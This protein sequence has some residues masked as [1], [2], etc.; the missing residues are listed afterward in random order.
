MMTW[1]I[2]LVGIAASVLLVFGPA[3]ASPKG[4]RIC[5]ARDGTW[6][7]KRKCAAGESEVNASSLASLL[8]AGPPGRDGTPGAPGAPGA[9]GPSDVYTAGGPN[10]ILDFGT[11]ETQILSL[12]SLPANAHFLV[13]AKARLN[14]TITATAPNAVSCIL[15][16]LPDNTLIDVSWAEMGSGA[17]QGQLATVSL[18]APLDTSSGTTG[19]AF[20]CSAAAQG[21]S[22]SVRASAFKLA[23][24]QT[25][26]VH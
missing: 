22:E 1:P 13:L 3:H 9:P 4:M 20:T 26:M 15:R 21:A 8:P 24:V 14:G 6:R 5:A 17:G 10:D 7:A 23:A 11:V 25:E 16:S 19:V 12:P 18:Q 2:S